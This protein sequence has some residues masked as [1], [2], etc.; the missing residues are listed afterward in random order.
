MKFGANSE[1][2]ALAEDQTV[3][4][5]PE[6]LSHEQASC[7]CDGALTSYNFLSKLTQ[8]KAGDKVLINGAAGSLGSFATKLAITYKAELTVTCSK[9]NVEY[10]NAMGKLRVLDYRS[11]EFKN[12]KDEFDVIFDAVGMLDTSLA[13]Q[14]LK[15]NGHYLTPVLSLNILFKMIFSRF[16]SKKYSFAATGM[17]EPK[18]LL[19][20]LDSLLNLMDKKSLSIDIE[21]VF[22]YENLASAHELVDTGHKRA[23]YILKASEK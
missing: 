1:Y 9:D 22:P 6:F 16:S 7:I 3:M 18:I 5:K 17:L 13:S 11:S 21:K 14:M 19:G 12:L 2:I 23:N 10:L 8:I 4:K 20:Y 15:N